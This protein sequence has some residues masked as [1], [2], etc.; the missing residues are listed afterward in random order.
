[1]RR[2]VYR[3]KL[4]I[5]STVDAV[6]QGMMWSILYF[7]PFHGFLYSCSHVDKRYSQSSTGE[8]FMYGR[9]KLLRLIPCLANFRIRFSSVLSF[10]IRLNKASECC[11]EVSFCWR[12]ALFLSRYFLSDCRIFSGYFSRYC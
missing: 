1:M 9:R 8:R 11:L 12:A 7:S 5:S 6:Q 4:S 2:F 10:L 3:N